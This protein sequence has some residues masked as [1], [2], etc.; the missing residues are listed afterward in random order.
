MKFTV[1]QRVVFLR[2]PGGGRILAEEEKGN[3]RVED[4]DG[5]IRIVHQ[6]VLGIVHGESYELEDL[7]NIPLEKDK[8]V[9]ERISKPQSEVILWEIDLHI[10]ELVDPHAGWSNAEI[11]K[12]Q[13]SA[14]HSFYEKARRSRIRKAIVIHGVGEGVLRSE[15]RSWLDKQE[16]VQCEDA[17][18]RQYGQGATLVEFFYR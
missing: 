17:D 6:T 3:Y 12:R 15:V 14:L 8:P 13:L 4:D 2:E 10:E 18:F 16:G 1:G 7:E 5:F 9:A 11:L